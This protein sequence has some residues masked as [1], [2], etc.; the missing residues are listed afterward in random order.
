MR[1]LAV[2]QGNYG[3]RMVDHIGR[4]GP[5]DWSVETFLPPPFLPIILD[6]PDSDEVE[7]YFDPLS[8]YLPAIFGKRFYKKVWE[9]HLMHTYLHE[10][11]HAKHG[12]K[13]GWR[14]KVADHEDAAETFAWRWLEKRFDHLEVMGAMLLMWMIEDMG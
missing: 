6:D 13:N 3:Q 10:I 5:E 14:G 12:L 1:I 11:G 9:V 4:R 8:H 2:V 7:S